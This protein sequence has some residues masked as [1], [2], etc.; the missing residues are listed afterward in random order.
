MASLFK[1]FST[2]GKVKAPFTLT[3]VELVKRDLLNEFYTRKGE[4]LMRPEFG[5]IVWEL[6]MNPEDSFTTDEIR[7]DVER[8]IAKDQRVELV[9]ISIFTLDHSVRIEVEL[10]YVILNS[11]DTL[12]LEFSTEEQV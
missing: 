5:S 10:N 11:R 12:F 7:E 2:V 4:R 8:I 3:D 6:L 1:G 9:D